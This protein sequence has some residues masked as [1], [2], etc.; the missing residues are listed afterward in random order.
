MLNRHFVTFPGFPSPIPPLIVTEHAKEVF[1]NGVL[2]RFEE[3]DNEEKLIL[4]QGCV[5]IAWLGKNDVGNDVIYMDIYPAFN[6]DDGRARKKRDGSDYKE[7]EYVYTNEPMGGYSGR[8][9]E[10]FLKIIEQRIEDAVNKD[11]KEE[12]IMYSGMYEIN[13]DKKIV[14]NKEKVMGFGV[15]LGDAKNVVL[16]NFRFKSTNLNFNSVKYHPDFLLINYFASTH[17]DDINALYTQ[18]YFI[19]RTLPNA[20]AKAFFLALWNQLQSEDKPINLPIEEDI[21]Y[22][23]EDPVIKFEKIWEEKYADNP[24]ERIRGLTETLCKF[25]TQKNTNVPKIKEIMEAIWRNADEIKE[26]DKKQKKEFIIKHLTF[27]ESEYKASALRILIE[28]EE[29]KKNNFYLFEAIFENLFC[30]P[31]DVICGDRSATKEELKSIE[32]ELQGM[33]YTDSSFTVMLQLLNKETLDDMMKIEKF[34]ELKT[35][36]D[37]SEKLLYGINTEYTVDKLIKCFK[38]NKAILEKEGPQIFLRWWE[39]VGVNEKDITPIVTYLLEHKVNFN[40]CD[41]NGNTPLITAFQSDKL[42]VQILLDLKADTLFQNDQKETP[43]MLALTDNNIE[44]FQYCIAHKIPFIKDIKDV[45]EI[46]PILQLAIET[47]EVETFSW[48]LNHGANPNSFMENNLTLLTAVITNVISDGKKYEDD[49]K[50]EEVAIVKILLDQ[51]A[52]PKNKV[53][54]T[55]LGKAIESDELEFVYLLLQYGVIVDD[56]SNTSLLLLAA[57]NFRLET[58]FKAYRQR[59]ETIKIAKDIIQVFCAENKDY[60]IIESYLN[61][62]SS[63]SPSINDEN[64]LKNFLS[65]NFS[66]SILYDDSLG[67]NFPNS[68]DKSKKMD[69]HSE[70]NIKSSSIVFFKPKEKGEDLSK[71]N[72]LLIEL[73]NAINKGI[74]KEINQHQKISRY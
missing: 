31:R 19:R 61:T 21:E 68:E 66:E 49:E 52:D 71:E 17:S 34:K 9:H 10:Q 54:I 70:K 67:K 53:G 13:A 18:E 1:S 16:S 25:M 22:V 12:L 3:K 39:T 4:G 50:K 64:K 38:E 72:A 32:N 28:K 62:L 27:Y 20:L 74:K 23:L 6:K 40:F 48:L 43:V 35:T 73:Q 41:E 30:I 14:I 11:K 36:F 63:L 47:K 69:E 65:E 56:E 45:S 7:G 46:M 8:N 51:K 15:F 29:N 59:I 26:L 37:K 44:F 5:G 57:Q 60:K 24:K 33:S 42:L 2:A 58:E 55:P